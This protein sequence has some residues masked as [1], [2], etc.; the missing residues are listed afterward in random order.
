MA[1]AFEMGVM[2]SYYFLY[3]GFSE[4]FW[5][6]GRTRQSPTRKH[7]RIGNDLYVSMDALIGATAAFGRLMVLRHCKRSRMDAY[8]PI[9]VLVKY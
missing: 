6:G 2:V 7:V 9:L 5:W 1:F 8:L 4:A 3:A